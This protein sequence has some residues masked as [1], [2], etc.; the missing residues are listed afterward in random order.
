MYRLEDV[1]A[2]SALSAA[3]CATQWYA[4]SD[5]RGDCF[6]TPALA[7]GVREV[8]LVMTFLSGFKDKQLFKNRSNEGSTRVYIYKKSKMK[9]SAMYAAKQAGRNCIVISNQ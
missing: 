4:I 6:A 7:G 9:S 8:R 2:R 1:I 5:K 3:T